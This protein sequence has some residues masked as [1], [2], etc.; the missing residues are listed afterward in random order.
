METLKATV[1]LF[2]AMFGGASGANVNNNV[3]PSHIVRVSGTVEAAKAVAGETP[4]YAIKLD[5]PTNIDGK[6]VRSIEICRGSRCMRLLL[7]KRVT[8]TC[9]ITGKGRGQGDCPRLVLLA[10]IREL[11]AH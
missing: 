4:G 9:R 3:A 11:K 5:R 6:M 2:L 7:N 8:A 10:D 1:L